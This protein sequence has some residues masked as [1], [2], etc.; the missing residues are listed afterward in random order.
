MVVR[1]GLILAAIGVA[2]GIG[3]SVLCTRAMA[4]MLFKTS[5]V[6]P[7]IFV[8]SSFVLVA[9]AAAASFVPAC[10]AAFVDPIEALKAE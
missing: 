1:E 6:D 7:P 2:I 3:L 9:V 4:S 5:A 10:K 8:A